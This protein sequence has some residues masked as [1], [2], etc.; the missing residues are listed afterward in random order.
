MN[1]VVI[2][3][4]FLAHLSATLY[5]TGLIWFVQIV[6]YPLL[7]AVG[8][9]EF[10]AY[11][12]QHLSL[13]GWVVIPPM[14][15]EI[16]TAGLMLWFRPVGVTSWQAGVGIGLLMMVWLSTAFLQVP[17]HE[18]LVNG[19]RADVHQRLVTTNWIRTVAWTLRGLLILWMVWNTWA[20]TWM[21]K[22]SSS[23]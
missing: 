11:E 7:A 13:T 2:R 18:T 4:I 6:H 8:Q 14:F 23:L 3:L 22:P 10:S 21:T 5:M 1:E 19:F 12:Q 15:V 17:C 9:K 16:A 20:V